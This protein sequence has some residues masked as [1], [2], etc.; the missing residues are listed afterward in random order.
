VLGL[1]WSLV[2]PVFLLAIYTFVFGVVF[3]PRWALPP[4][5]RGNFALLVFS[6]II[7][8]S[9]FAECAGRAPGLVLANVS[10]VKR[11]VFPLQILPWVALGVALFNAAMSGIVLMAF[12]AITVGLPPLTVLWLPV[13]LVP[14]VLLCAGVSWFFAGLGVYLRDLQPLV[15]VLIAALNFLSP[16]F[17]PLSAIPEP[18]RHALEVNPLAVVLEATKASLFYD[19]RPSA[20][21][22]LASGVVSLLVAW[23]GHAAFMRLRPG[24]ADVV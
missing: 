20:R 6:G 10:Y 19:V 12:Y 9:V 3:A 17:Y 1:L 5:G 7:I 8:F 21:A 13:T 22:L 4:G 11:V 24:F 23:A 2:V 18:Y 16:V 15:G 14:L